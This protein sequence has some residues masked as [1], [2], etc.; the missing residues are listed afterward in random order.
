MSA[1]AP[2]PLPRS[3][4]AVVA[5]RLAQLSP[6]ARRLA[7]IAA[8]IGRSFA[9]SLLA[10][11][12]AQ[13]DEE[14]VSALDEL[15][16]RRLV[17]EHGDEDYEFSHDTIRMVAYATLNAA[18][19]RL[20]H[21]RIAAALE[22]RTADLD[23]GQFGL[24]ARHHEMAGNLERAVELYGRAAHVASRVY[25][26]A[27]AVAHLRHA[28]DLL[29]SSPRAA[30]RGAAWQSTQAQLQES[31]GDLLL[32]TGEHRDAMCAHAAAGNATQS[33]DH[34]QHARLLRKMATACEGLRDYS[35]ALE[36]L[37]LAEAALE[38]E[39]TTSTDDAVHE[40]IEIQLGRVRVHYWTGHLEQLAALTSV[41]RSVVQRDGT[42]RQR[43]SFL[44][45]LANEGLRRERYVASDETLATSR[46]AWCAALAEPCSDSE[47][48]AS[49]RFALG[50]VLL[51]RGELAE[52][53]EHL[54]AVRTATE[55]IRHTPLLMRAIVY[56]AAH[57]RLSG[58]I[59][60]ARH[61]AS[62]ALAL[63]SRAEFPEYIG[64]ALAILG[65]ADLR[66]GDEARATS[67]L[68][69][70]VDAWGSSPEYPFTWLARWPLLQVAIARCDLTE[71]IEHAC[72][73]LDGT[74]QRLPER[75][76][77]ELEAAIAAAQDA[78]AAAA[79]ME[80]ALD[81]ARSVGLL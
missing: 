15:L 46:A 62:H 25:A 14:V 54:L 30:N 20:Q 81:L 76:A 66:A 5:G 19:R 72:A 32:L 40:W 9:F 70:A 23:D 29:N 18:R 13:P 31:L 39:P 26:N 69:A 61:L 17:R 28:L 51:C 63:A 34:V 7:G 52:A 45:W 79:H 49:A 1:G 80:A 55:H 37:D 10:N 4:E 2:G 65:W 44:Q 12:A 71:A 48:S 57:S 3:V 36:R 75:I 6:S 8:T 16:K 77:T 38:A 47:A 33:A 58:W 27:D 73:L 68:H 56:L 11:A 42:P 41:L 78:E 50:L 35:A 24:L 60:Q 59:D 43:V 21:R 67:Q 74:Q 64:A 53:G 22:A